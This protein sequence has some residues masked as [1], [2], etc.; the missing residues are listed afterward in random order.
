MN[1]CFQSIQAPAIQTAVCCKFIPNENVIIVSRRL[2]LF[3]YTLSKNNELCERATIPLHANALHLLAYRPLDLEQ[4]YLLIVTQDGYYFSVY[5]DDNFGKVALDSPLQMCTTQPSYP[6]TSWR[7]FCLVNQEAQ[8]VLIRT[9]EMKVLCLS[10]FSEEQRKQQGF[11]IG[12]GA[13]LLLPGY[14]VMDMCFLQHGNPP[15]VAVLSQTVDSTKVT[16]HK[17]NL[18]S[19]SFDSGSVVL[20]NSLYYKLMAVGKKGLIAL[21]EDNISYFNRGTVISI[22]A[23]S[24]RFS[25]YCAL[26]GL[27][28]QFVLVSAE[29]NVYTLS[30]NPLF[31]KLYTLM[32]EELPFS[33]V[34]NVSSVMA[35]DEERLFASNINGSIHI[36]SLPSYTV[37]EITAGH[38][39]IHDMQFFESGSGNTLLLCAG[40]L[41]SGSL[42]YLCN[43]LSAEPISLFDLSGVLHVWPVH[44]QSV[45]KLFVGMA[46]ETKVFTMVSLY[47]AEFDPELSLDESTLALSACENGYVQITNKSLRYC[48][49]TS[50]DAIPLE[51]ITSVSSL[52]AYAAIV[53]DNTSLVIYNMTKEIA[54]TTFSKEVSAVD[55]AS[56]LRIVVGFWNKTMEMLAIRDNSFICVLRK[57][58]NFIPRDVLLQFSNDDRLHLFMGSDEGNLCVATVEKSLITNMDYRVLGSTPIHFTRLLISTGAYVICTNDKPHMVY[59]LHGKLAFM[60]L[61]VPSSIDLNAFLDEKLR[62]CLVSAHSEGVSILHLD[63]QPKL[64]VTRLKTK[65][66]PQKAA[67]IDQTVLFSGLKQQPNGLGELSAQYSL[68]CSKVY[69]QF[70]L[71]SFKLDEFEECTSVIASSSSLFVVTTAKKYPYNYFSVSGRLLVIKASSENREL[72]VQSTYSHSSGFASCV[73]YGKC[74]FAASDDCILTFVLDATEV[75]LIGTTHCVTVLIQLLVDEDRLITVD[76]FGALTVYQISDSQLVWLANIQSKPEWAYHACVM[77][78]F[79]YLTFAIDGSVHQIQLLND[80]ND[81]SPTGFRLESTC[82]LKLHDR[83]LCASA[84]SLTTVKKDAPLSPQITFGTELGAVGSVLQFDEKKE[85][86]I[87]LQKAIWH[88]RLNYVGKYELPIESDHSKVASCFVDASLFQLAKNWTQEQLYRLVRDMDGLESLN[89]Q[90]K[91]NRVLNE[92]DVVS[93]VDLSSVA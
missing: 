87:A 6:N 45:L 47:E 62:F 34:F 2:Q 55:F 72:D 88:Q 73:E 1:L 93:K 77:R 4:D 38:G 37:S 80:N 56:P 44:F 70:E 18:Q 27:K 20:K 8:L 81:A 50:K 66:L 54:R 9:S 33:P 82:S 89:S 53:I 30:C 49:E 23:P 31:H 10:I 46:N 5:W 3:V 36:L 32:V 79:Q 17:L 35:I 40:S 58:L 84:G 60:P 90:E 16:V 39:A 14:L 91:I 75:R 68:V 43:S 83:V 52:G 11:S 28:R 15:Q 48:T 21:G 61:N 92:L 22:R 12:D 24:V 86:Y 69:D 51:G 26:R 85:E 76:A 71:C 74:L 13:E 65:L 41:N 64:S 67:I 63:N 57:S 7:S 59:G 25:H 29:G 42:I 78:P 19:D